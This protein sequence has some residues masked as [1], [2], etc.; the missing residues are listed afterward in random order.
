MSLKKKYLKSRPICKV[1]FT[2][3]LDA[4]GDVEEIR[5]LG[6]WNGWEW[7]EG[8]SMKKTKA[9]YSVVAELPQDQMYEFKYRTK[10][11]EWI[12][13]WEADG[14]MPSPYGNENSMV[15]TFVSTVGQE[16]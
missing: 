4:V 10:E 11:G 3:P 5:V 2:L 6:D 1:T 16:G 13:D 7:E 14:Y 12:N 8:L 15:E 9:A